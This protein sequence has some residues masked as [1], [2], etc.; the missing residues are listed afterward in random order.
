MV[1]SSD[2]QWELE[3]ESLLLLIKKEPVEVRQASDQAASLH[4]FEGF[5]DMH[6]YKKNLS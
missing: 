5:P 6:N 1:R 2:I 4:S 3:V